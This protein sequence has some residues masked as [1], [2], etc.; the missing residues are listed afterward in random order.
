MINSYQRLLHI[1]YHNHRSLLVIFAIIV[2]LSIY[3]LNKDL[4][5]KVDLSSVSDGNYLLV[6]VPVLYSDTLKEAQLKIDNEYESYIIIDISDLNYDEYSKT[7][8][9]IYTIGINKIYP[10]NQIVKLSF[11]YNKEK[12][13]KKVIKLIKE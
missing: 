2:F 7:N 12:I 11:Y 4:Y 3:I 9:Q 8:Y 1:P 6:T 13:F 5:D 10:E